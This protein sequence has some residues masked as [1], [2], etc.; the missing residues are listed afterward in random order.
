[1][2]D[3]SRR[4]LCLHNLYLHSS[5]GTTKEES[6]VLREKKADAG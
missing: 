3:I 6:Y 5:V 2:V 1:V 4:L